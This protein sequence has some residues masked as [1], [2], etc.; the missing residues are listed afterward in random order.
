MVMDWLRV[1][2]EANVIPF[3]K[4]VDKTCW[5]YYPE[6]INMLKD[7]VNIPGISMTYM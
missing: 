3:I 1:Y 2:N 6:K 7:M 5:Q 4:A